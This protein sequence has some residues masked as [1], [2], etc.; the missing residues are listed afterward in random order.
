MCY[1]LP[2]TSQN[3]ISQSV[4][5]VIC[6]DHWHSILSNSKPIGNEKK[7]KPYL[8]FSSF[9]AQII[10]SK[11]VQILC[12]QVGHAAN[13]HFRPVYQFLQCASVIK[14]KVLRQLPPLSSTLCSTSSFFLDLNP[15]LYIQP[16]FWFTIW[17][18][19]NLGIIWTFS[20]AMLIFFVSHNFLLGL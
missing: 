11:K 14:I 3:H 13:T 19:K 18:I 2:R 15:S 6:P 17:A 8:Y 16:C 5:F 10:L 4:V 7:K 12:V 1:S 20:L 9:Q